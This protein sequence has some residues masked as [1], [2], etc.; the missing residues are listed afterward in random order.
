MSDGT[1]VDEILEA[2]EAAGLTEVYLNDLRK[3]R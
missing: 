1:H 2:L 3:H